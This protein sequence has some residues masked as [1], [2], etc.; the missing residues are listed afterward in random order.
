M[1]GINSP[2]RNYLAKNIFIKFIKE[3]II[4]IMETE[5]LLYFYFIIIILSYFAIFAFIIITISF[6]QICTKCSNELFICRCIC[7]F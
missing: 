4:S 3:Y 1:K 5:V 2:I 7:Q 6:I